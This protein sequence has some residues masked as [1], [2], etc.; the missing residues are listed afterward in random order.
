MWFKNLLIYRFTKPFELDA[1]QLEQ[2][3]FEKPFKTCGTQDMAT[4]GWTSPIGE[5]GSSLVHAADGRLMLCLQ[6]QEKVLPTAVVNEAVEAKLA[7]IKTRESRHVGRK[8][9]VEIKEQIVFELLPRAFAKSNK[10]F[11]YIDP[12]AAL[13][14]INT[15]SGSQAEEFMNT[16]RESLGSLP[17]VPLK[18]LNP[19]QDCMT[20]WLKENQAPEQFV[21]GGEC[22]LRDRTDTSAVIRC[23]NLDLQ[24]AEIKHHIESGMYV[25]KL[26][27]A[28]TGGIECLIDDKFAVKRLKYQ[29][30]ITDKLDEEEADTAAEQ[31]DVNFVLMANEFA[32]FIPALVNGFGGPEVQL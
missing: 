5:E 12:A 32:N 25:N 2:Q 22:E 31:F 23:K 16:L 28:W 10:V 21:I 14:V 11:G 29:E 7:D 8:E 13:L 17:V 1:D 3:L 30:L 26:E 6:R 19:L 27:M 15:P 18:P 24:G 4:R 20:R 9:R